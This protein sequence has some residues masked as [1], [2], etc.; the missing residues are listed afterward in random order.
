MNLQDWIRGKSVLLRLLIFLYFI[1]D[2]FAYSQ[3]I[4]RNNIWFPVNYAIHELG[5]F[6]TAFLPTLICIAA[7]TIF[8]LLLPL[9]GLFCFLR[10]RD[11]FGIAITLDWLASN[12]FN[13]S[14]YVGSSTDVEWVAMV[15]V[16]HGDGEIIHDWNY[17]LT[18][19]G[20]LGYYHSI[21]NFFLILGWTAIS[22][23]ILF[24][25]YIIWL[26]F[27]LKRETGWY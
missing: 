16:F 10:Q 1:Y 24:G 14:A 9:Y 11:Y 8:Q 12:F 4:D 6:V 19:L 13:I 5:H 3:N 2:F 21:S 22:A 17:L 23:A 15:T 27:K 26:M 25:G 7:G 18:D 20:I